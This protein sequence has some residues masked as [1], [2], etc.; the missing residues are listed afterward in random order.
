VLD[1]GLAPIDD[2]DVLEFFDFTQT[3]VEIVPATLNYFQARVAE[4]LREHD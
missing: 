1:F 4:I 3:E 2:L